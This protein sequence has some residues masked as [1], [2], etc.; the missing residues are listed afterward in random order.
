MAEGKHGL[1]EVCVG[2]VELCFGVYVLLSLPEIPLE[3]VPIYFVAGLMLSIEGAIHI[4]RGD[5]R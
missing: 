5:R 4:N 2:L 1:K 3:W